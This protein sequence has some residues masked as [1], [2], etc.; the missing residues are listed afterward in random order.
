MIL[1]APNDKEETE[2][3]RRTGWPRGDGLNS[4]MKSNADET[5]G[6]A[7]TQQR[8]VMFSRVGQ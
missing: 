7:L 8:G 5:V 4:S 2:R 3:L 6:K 1:D